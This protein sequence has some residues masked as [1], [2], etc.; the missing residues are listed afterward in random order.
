MNNLKKMQPEQSKKTI[1][2]GYPFQPLFDHMLQE[3]GVKL[4]ESEMTDIVILCDLLIKKD[5]DEKRAQ[6]E[7]LGLIDEKRPAGSTWLT[8][9]YERLYDQLK[10]EPERKIVCWVNYTWRYRDEKEEILRDICAIRGRHLEFSSRGH[11]YGGAQYLLENMNG[12]DEFLKECER[13]QVQ[14]LDE[15]S[16]D[17]ADSTNAL[18]Q[19]ANYKHEC[20]CMPCVGQC[21]T[22]E[23]LQVEIEWLIEIA[24]KTLEA[25]KEGKPWI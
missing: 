23:A 21:R 12:K 6:A 18:K 8:G 13:L 20:G 1:Y 15:S 10:A 5:F 2:P 17:N 11:G 14:W 25:K 16:A 22:A 24:A 7:A 19:I 3:H 9:Q 4:L